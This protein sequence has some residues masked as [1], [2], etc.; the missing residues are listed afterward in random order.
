MVM[1]SRLAK[2]IIIAMSL[3]L[4]APLYLMRLQSAEDLVA[5]HNRPLQSW[6]RAIQ[7]RRSPALYFDQVNRWVSDRVY[8]IVALSR[9]KS[10][11]AY[12][13]MAQAPSANITRGS[14]GLLFL[15]G[16]DADHENNLVDNSCRQASDPENLKRLEAAL[17][18]IAEFGRR[19]G[20]PIDLLMVPT[21]PILYGDRLPR[22]LSS[23]LREA[24]AASFARG[25]PAGAVRAP[26][27]LHVVYPFPELKAL[28]DDLAMYPNGNYHAIGL[29]VRTA[30]NAYLA[31][32]GAARSATSLTLSSGPSE[33]LATRDM[34]VAFPRY[35]VSDGDAVP[36]DQMASA[37]TDLTAP[38]RDDPGQTVSAYA[39]PAA[40]NPDTVLV[41]S[42]SFG[43]NQAFD[44]A[45]AFRAVAQMQTPHRDLA[46]MIESMRRVM[47]FTR[48][49][50]VYNDTNFERLS[51]VGERLSM[52]AGR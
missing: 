51:E 17:D 48:I 52:P 7:Y 46:A 42:N 20:Y 38:F 18:R 27:G 40:P 3:S 34:D 47:P 32:I 16:T 13:V 26:S 22:S 21:M 2:T 9:I 43:T 25:G 36:D 28:R 12:D 23:S 41:L 44:L 10:Y 39:D 45:L 33:A 37:L 8:P 14:D 35:D 30:T 49:V 5:F 24:C 11:F 15:N 1:I 19:S 6:P 29:S 4:L 50:L 31:A